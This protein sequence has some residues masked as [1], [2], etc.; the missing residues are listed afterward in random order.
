MSSQRTPIVSGLLVRLALLGLCAAPAIANAFV[1]G[2]FVTAS[3]GHFY[4][5]GQRV[6][7]WGENVQL[8]Q[9]TSSARP[10]EEIDNFVARISALGYNGV[11]LWA[12]QDTFY[13]VSGN[14]RVFP[15]VRKSD[16]SKLD[17]FDYLVSKLSAANISIHMTALHNVGVY[18]LDKDP[19]AVVSQWASE[20]REKFPAEPDTTNAQ[21][22][23]VYTF[24]PY[25]SKDWRDMM[26]AHQGAFLSHLNPYTNRTYAEEPAVS[27][28]ELINESQFVG[29]SLDASCIGSLPAIAQQ[30]LNAA[31]VAS[32]YNTFGSTT[33][34]DGLASHYSAYAHFVSKAFID[35]SNELRANAKTF[36]PGVAAQ[37]FIFNTGLNYTPNSAT[38]TAP[39]AVALYA[40]GQGDATSMDGYRSPLASSKTGGFGGTPWI[41]VAMGGAMPTAMHGF[42]VK[43]KPHVIY[44][45]SF[46]RPYPYRAEWGTV[47]AAFALKQDWD[48]VYLYAQGDAPSIYGSGNTGLNAQYG[49]IRL[50]EPPAQSGTCDKSKYTEGFKH[51]GD[52]AVQASW[53]LGGRLVTRVSESPAL[54]ITW[55][56]D[57]NTLFTPGANN[58]FPSGFLS[59]LSDARTNTSAIEFTG[60]TT[61]PCFKCVDS[62]AAVPTQFSID[63]DLSRSQFLR[64]LVVTAPGIGVAASGYLTGDLGDLAGYRTAIQSHSGFGTVGVMLSNLSGSAN[65]SH[66]LLL[67]GNVANTDYFFDPAKAEVGDSAGPMCGVTNTGRAPILWTQPEIKFTYGAARSYAPYGFDFSARPQPPRG[68]AFVTSIDGQGGSGVFW[69]DSRP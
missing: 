36:G 49:T 31:W 46:F 43:G 11:R 23:K 67:V 15:I 65:T 20:T 10:Y 59:Q 37:S 54:Q 4:R 45:T 12:T 48:A 39:N 42:R 22:L 68:P 3:S 55:K 7:F 35:A 14:T 50:P 19:N 32:P 1:P 27:A 61:P 34:Q 28:W 9:I 29:C 44:E 16:G 41:P 58:G 53:V 56:I 25:V 5:N 57:D 18:S 24:A 30:S 33:A 63:W 60:A 38:S 64:R 51:G 52:P 47:M 6:R 17:L 13:V 69:I 8:G 21:Q 62:N 26:K 40:G 2:D 66:T